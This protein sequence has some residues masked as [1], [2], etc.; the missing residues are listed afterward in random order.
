MAFSRGVSRLGG[1]A[2]TAR[3]EEVARW[4]A[5]AR[6]GAADS[7]GQAL[8][9]CRG[10][11]LSI[12]QQELDPQLRTKAGASD[13]VQE[14]FLKAHRHFAHFHG[15]AEEEL[16]AWLRRLLLN[17]LVDFRRLYQETQKRDAALEL[18]LSD[19]QLLGQMESGL[20]ADEPS[21]SALAMAREQEEALQRTL[22]RLPEDYRRVLVW[23]HQEERS[24]EE[25]GH[26]MSRSANAARKLWARAVQRFQEEWEGGHEPR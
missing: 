20:V 16:L 11:L 13:L 17:N 9:A 25:I 23:R 22:T 1:K 6:G 3:A 18:A 4:L 8:E 19:W 12:A 26:L 2:M 14:T 7:L 10:Y 5:E 15:T 21:P 24:F